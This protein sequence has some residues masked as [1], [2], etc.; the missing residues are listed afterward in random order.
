MTTPPPHDSER[1]LTTNQH[2]YDGCSIK[3]AREN[4]PLWVLW[5][6]VLFDRWSNSVAMALH[7]SEKTQNK[8]PRT[9]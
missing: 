3:A 6:L 9:G 2:K 4:Y 8:M 5:S 1:L 7:W